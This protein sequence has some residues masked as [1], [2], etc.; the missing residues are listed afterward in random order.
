MTTAAAPPDTL[1]GTEFPLGATI[2]EGGTNFAVASDV[3][4]SSEMGTPRTYATRT[5]T[6]R[7]CRS[8]GSAIDGQ[9]LGAVRRWS[10]RP[11]RRAMGALAQSGCR[12]FE[13]ACGRSEPGGQA[14]ESC[15]VRRW[16][17]M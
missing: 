13:H 6:G 10:T 17:Q 2:R 1:P 15:E 8:S 12:R 5:A 14:A 9:K 3:E 7:S 11:V 16:R 4:R